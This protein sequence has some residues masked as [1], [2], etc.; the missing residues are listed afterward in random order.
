MFQVIFSEGDQG[1]TITQNI[2][3]INTDRISKSWNIYNTYCVYSNN[4]RIQNNIYRLHQA[5][6]VLQELLQA[7]LNCFKY[8]F[9]MEYCSY[10]WIDN[11]YDLL[12]KVWGILG[13][14]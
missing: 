4:N 5:G 3:T 10:F 13:S 7:T 1:N 9:Y 12:C 8:W 6:P 2:T 14:I 11:V